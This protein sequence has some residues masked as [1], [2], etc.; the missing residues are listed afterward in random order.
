MNTLYLFR[1]G[2]LNEV[3][4][5]VPPEVFE[6]KDTVVVEVNK[7]ASAGRQ[8]LRGCL[9]GWTSEPSCRPTPFEMRLSTI[10]KRKYLK[11]WIIYPNLF[12]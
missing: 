1:E 4:K 5:R 7:L 12:L 6:A 10:V 11:V 9:T 8:H 3:L 2:D